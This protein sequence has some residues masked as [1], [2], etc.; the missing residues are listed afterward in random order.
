[1]SESSEKFQ[2]GDRHFG[3]NFCSISA[4]CEVLRLQRPDT[5]VVDNTTNEEVLNMYFDSKGLG[6][7]F[8]DE[9]AMD[10]AKELS[11]I[12]H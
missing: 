7:C 12:E 8:P 2:V 5:S 10:I 3:R 11:S 6:G 4:S 9:V 1:M